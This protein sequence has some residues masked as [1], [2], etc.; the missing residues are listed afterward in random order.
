MK[1]KNEQ[2]RIISVNPSLAERLK[3]DDR[4]TAIQPEYETDST[5]EMDDLERTETDSED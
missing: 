4:Y 2:G 3:E 1:F 5:H